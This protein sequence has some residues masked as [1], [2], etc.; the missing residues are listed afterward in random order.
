MVVSAER[1]MVDRDD[2]PQAW[3]D[4]AAAVWS[5]LVAFDELP[6]EATTKDGLAH[7]RARFL[8]E[9]RERGVSE[10]ELRLHLRTASALRAFGDTPCRF[11]RSP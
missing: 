6:V 3:I 8:L 11:R 1:L 5:V 2:V 9:L 7:V 10:G 4:D